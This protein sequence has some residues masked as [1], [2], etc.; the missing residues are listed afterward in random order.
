MRLRIR[1]LFPAVLA[2][3]VLTPAVASAASLVLPNEPV[4]AALDRISWAAVVA[5]LM[6]ALAAHLALSSLGI[7]I[8]AAG[9]DA[10]DRTN[11]IEG[12]PTTV[13]I[14]MFVSGLIALFVGGWVAGRLAGTVPLDSAIH[15]AI[16]WAVATVTLFLL[17]A[18]SLGA[19]ISGTF[20]VLVSGTSAVARAATAVVPA[21]AGLAKEV[22]ADSAPAL[23]WKGIQKEAKKVLGG[24][25][26]AKDG[27]AKGSGQ[28]G[29]TSTEDIDELLTK[30][31]GTVRDGLAAGDREELAAAI[32]THT[33][34]SKEDA[35]KM[36]EKWEKAYGE[37]KQAYKKA[38]TKAE[39][40]ARDT[41]AAAASAVSRVAVWTFFSLVLGAAVATAGGNLGSTYFR[42]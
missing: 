39:V 29:D 28:G 2:I 32:T 27:E 7:A 22:V 13:M 24:N 42:L 9:I 14:W 37:A 11:P 18:T 25:G 35:N 40:V 20:H 5:G 3:A 38:V 15:G 23:D 30:A 19:V 16:T 17:A 6:V 12:V 8:G 33:E 4:I 41:A 1:Y 31:Y 36:L 21:A 34:M 10:H 26:K